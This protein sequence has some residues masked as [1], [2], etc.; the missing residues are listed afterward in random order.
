[1]L[2]RERLTRRSRDLQRMLAVRQRRPGLHHARHL[3]QAGRQEEGRR[4][5]ERP[6]V[7]E[8]LRTSNPLQTRVVNGKDSQLTRHRRTLPLTP[9][10]PFASPWESSL[11]SA[12]PIPRWPNGSGKLQRQRPFQLLCTMKLRGWGRVMWILAR[13]VDVSCVYIMLLVDRYGYVN[14]KRRLGQQKHHLE[15]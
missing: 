11:R 6:L 13:E 8:P 15:I 14:L 10:P 2:R 12:P 5:H 4:R 7:A 3:G 1:M 9:W